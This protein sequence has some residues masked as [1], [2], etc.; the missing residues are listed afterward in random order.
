MK[1]IRSVHERSSSS[2]CNICSNVCER[3]NTPASSWFPFFTLTNEISSLK[4]LQ[5]FP[6]FQLTLNQRVCSTKVSN[7]KDTNSPLLP[8]CCCFESTGGRST[9]T[10]ARASF[11]SNKYCAILLFSEYPILEQYSNFS[12]TPTY[13]GGTF[14]EA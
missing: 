9:R 11:T 1:L 5:V 14:C 4:I 13:G 12:P 7:L 10:A 2:G 6:Y 3:K 8:V